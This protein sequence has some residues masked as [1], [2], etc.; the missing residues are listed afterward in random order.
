[1]HINKIVKDRVQNN[2]KIQVNLVITMSL[3][4]YNMNDTLNNKEA[5]NS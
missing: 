2:V 1:M 5:V 4:P 3:L